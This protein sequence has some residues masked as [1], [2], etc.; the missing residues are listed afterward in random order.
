MEPKKERKGG[1]VE[2][3]VALGRVKGIGS[4]LVV[5]QLLYRID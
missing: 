4:K 5:V 2:I 1:G 3:Q